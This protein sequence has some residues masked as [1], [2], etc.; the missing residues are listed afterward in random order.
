VNSESADVSNDIF[1]TYEY[2]ATGPPPRPFRPW[3]RPRKQFVRA[4]QWV[5]QTRALLAELPSDAS[6]RYLGLP[7]EDLLDVRAFH[8]A[9]GSDRGLRFLGFSTA[10]RGQTN[11]DLQVSLQEV[12]ALANVDAQSDVIPD[13]IRAIARTQSMGRKAALDA[14]PFDVV[15]LDLCDNFLTEEVGGGS[16][17]DAIAALC[18]L[19]NRRKHPWLFFVTT[20]IDRATV[21]AGICEKL[22]ELLAT[23]L[24]ACEAFSAAL[25]SMLG[26]PSRDSLPSLASCGD[27]DWLA[28]YC[29][30]LA[31]W[32][33]NVALTHHTQLEIKSTMSY[34]VAHGAGDDDL[35]SLAFKLTPSLASVPDKVGLASQEPAPF[36]ECALAAKLPGRT[37]RRVRVDAAL[38]NDEDLLERMIGDAAVLLVQAR[39]SANEYVDWAMQVEAADEAA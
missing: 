35:V 28:M 5:S 16:M 25:Q 7:G 18:A 19:Q 11:T 17:Y 13:D 1:A 30:A 37:T 29:V 31:K 10:R 8:H 14:G 26:A 9:F 27:E 33:L 15:N 34:R 21:D 36:D 12:K 2:E 39:Y 24:N 6:I 4:E 38:A 23:N 32:I 22:D 3:H 20:R